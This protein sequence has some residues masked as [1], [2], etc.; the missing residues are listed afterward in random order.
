MRPATCAVRAPSSVNVTL[1]K[2]LD[3]RKIILR[4]QIEQPDELDGG[5][6]YK[7]L[8]RF[9][10][11]AL[12]CSARADHVGHRIARRVGRTI[13]NSQL[14]LADHGLWRVTAAHQGREAFRTAWQRPPV[15]FSS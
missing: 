5:E 13:G 1:P 11:S 4:T 7:N 6:P 15:A 3:H 9:R 8:R 12:A 2:S 14:S 10:E